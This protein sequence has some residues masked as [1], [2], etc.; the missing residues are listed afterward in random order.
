MS[1]SF[2]PQTDGQTKRVN[3]T[4]ETYLRTFINYDQDDSYSVLPLAEFMYNNSVTQVTQLTPFFTNYRYYPKTIWTSSKESKNPASKADMHWIKVMQDRGTQ[5]LE[6]TQDYMSK[7]NDQHHQPQ[8][9]Y[10]EGD[11]VLLNVKN[12]WTVRPTKKLAP[13]LYEPFCILAR[14]GKSDYR[15]KLQS[16][17]QIHNIFHTSLLKLYQKRHDEKDD[18]RFNQNPKK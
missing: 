15:L 14:V 5:A 11:K 16:R 10:E 12:N 18:H 17:W 4:L 13:K 2:H 9:E 6:K 1:T 7:Y 8:P 3:Q